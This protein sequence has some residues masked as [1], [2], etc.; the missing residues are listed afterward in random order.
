MFLAARYLT[1]GKKLTYVCFNIADI[2]RKGL[3]RPEM[4]SSIT[5]TEIWL[6]RTP[7][8]NENQQDQTRS[9]F[10]VPNLPLAFLSGKLE[11]VGLVAKAPPDV[12]A[13]NPAVFESKPNIAT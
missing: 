4:L 1:I 6:I 5:Q 9:T 13:A 2:C 7:H 3:M 11:D 12:I 8:F 10:G